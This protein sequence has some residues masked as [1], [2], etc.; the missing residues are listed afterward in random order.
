MTPK[1]V[2]TLLKE[3]KVSQVPKGKVISASPEISIQ[4]AIEIMQ[5]ER[6]GYIALVKNKKVVGIFTETDVSR[7]ILGESI[8]LNTPVSQV[9]AHNPITIL[10]DDCVGKAIALMGE[11]RVYHLPVVDAEGRLEEVLSV[12]AL[13]RFLAEFYPTEVYNLPPDPDQVMKTAE[14]G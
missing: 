12:R 11:N 13:I 2:Q 8:D 10:E 5:Q 3:K 6:H 14:G 1:S 4:K 9:M 7:Q